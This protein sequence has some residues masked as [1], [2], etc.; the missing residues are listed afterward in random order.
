MNFKKYFCFEFLEFILST[1][2]KSCIFI[3]T[4]S[5]NWYKDKIT[6]VTSYMQNNYRSF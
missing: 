4:V 3:N 6:Y 1:F 5:D 2:H